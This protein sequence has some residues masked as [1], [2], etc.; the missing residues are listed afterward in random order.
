MLNVKRGMS[1]DH[2][3]RILGIVFALFSSFTNIV[4]YSIPSGR[5]LNAMIRISFFFTQLKFQPGRAE[6]ARIMNI[7]LR[8]G[9]IDR[10]NLI[11]PEQFV[12]GN[13]TLPF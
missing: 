11:L 8:V 4:N 5:F 1:G 6:D 2:K 3:G 10:T 13:T 9:D 12:C 7:K